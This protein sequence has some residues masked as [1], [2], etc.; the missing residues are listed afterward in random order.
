[1]IRTS[2]CQVLGIDHPIVQ[3]GMAG[4]YT[5]PELVAAVSNAGGLGVLGCLDRSPERARDDIDRIRSL[6]DRP[7]GVNF[8]LH[9]R[10]EETFRVCLDQKVP[11]FSFF[12]GDPETPVKQAHAA[13]AKVIHQ[14][15]T[16]QEARQAC[17]VGVDVLVAQGCEGGGHVGLLPLMSLLPEVVAAAGSRPVLAAGGIVDGRGLAAAMCL[18]AAGVL[19]GTRFLATEECS[20]SAIHKQEILKAGLGDTV[21][22]GEDGVWDMLWGHDWPG[23]QVRA[24]RNAMADWI[25]REDELRAVL[26]QE[27]EKFRRAYAEGDRSRMALLAGVGAGRI[28]RLQPAAEVVREIVAEAERILGRLAREAVQ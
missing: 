25:G 23:I 8:V 24:I 1:M 6:T 20:V 28:D 3:S 26:D 19:M 10:N 4:G 7:F 21:A 15:T 27:R 9:L 11:V 14:I 18:G 17:D 22:S 12:R 16:V 2:A 5:S 13:G